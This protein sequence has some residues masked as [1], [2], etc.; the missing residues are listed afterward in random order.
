M[1]DLIQDQKNGVLV[2]KRQPAALALAILDLLAQPS[3]LVSMSDAARS[4]A[5]PFSW[6]ACAQATAR[7]YEEVI[8]AS[9][10]LSPSC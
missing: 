7:A 3:R 6:A 5:E 4:T 1:A 10:S 9:L 2:P 8:S